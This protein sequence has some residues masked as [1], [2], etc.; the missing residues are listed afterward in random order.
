MR[1]SVVKYT[2]M[3]GILPRISDF[4]R[5]GFS[6]V[7]SFLAVIYG[8]VGLLPRNHPY[9]QPRNFG[10]F[11]IRHVFAEAGRNV[12]FSRDT[13][14]HVVIYFITLIAMVLI[15][16]QFVLL[17]FAFIYNPAFAGGPDY[18]FLLDAG[19]ASRIP[20][21]YNFFVLTPDGHSPSQDIA[22]VV[23]DKVFGIR[24]FSGTASTQSFF[25]SCVGDLIINTC[26]NIYGELSPLP[27][28]GGL[29]GGIPGFLPPINIFPKPIHFA[30]HNLLY[31]YTLGIAFL[32]GAVILYFIATIVGE[33]V[34]SGT[35]FG[36]RM[37][38]AWFIPRLIAFFA[39][40]APISGPS[41]SF[42]PLPGITNANNGINVAQL[43][44]FSAAKFG[45]NMAT[46][47]W[48]GF[49]DTAVANANSLGTAPPTA[50]LD[51][52][53]NNAVSTSFGVGQSM[54]ARPQVPEI[55]GLTHFTFLVRA[56]MYA[57][58]IMHG[59]PMRIYAVRPPSERTG[60]VRG[61]Q[62][63]PIPYTSLGNL[64]KLLDPAPAAVKEDSVDIT[65]FTD[66]IWFDML[67]S[68]ARFE[69]VVIRFGHRD[70]N[71]YPDEWGFVDP[72]CGEV[73]FQLTSLD[74]FVINNIAAPLPFGIQDAYFYLMMKMLTNEGV[75]ADELTYCMLQAT[76]PI[77]HRN[78]CVSETY[79][80]GGIAYPVPAP[81]AGPVDTHWLSTQAV[82]ADIEYFND[83]IR[84]LMIG[85]IS[86]W[87]LYTR[88]TNYLDATN[89]VGYITA[90]QNDE[91]VL[92]SVGPIELSVRSTLLM[93]VE[94]RQRGWAGA[95]LWYNRIAEINGM[96]SSAVNNK[97]VIYR[98]PRV[99]RQVEASHKS[100]TANLHEVE[101]FNP[102][103]PN[104]QLADLGRPGDQNI[105]ATLYSIHSFWGSNNIQETTYTRQSGNA[106]IDT[107][108]TL[109]GTSGIYDIANNSGTHPLAML[110]G[111]GKGMVDAALRNMFVGIVG[112]AGT[113]IGGDVVGPLAGLIGKFAFRFGMI[114][115]SIGFILYY[116]LPLMPFIYFFFA[117]SG[118][119]KSIFE[120]VVAMPLWAVAHIRIDGEGLPGPL[121]TN[122]YFLILEIFLRPSLII[123][124]FVLSVGIFTAL[125]NVLHS[126]FPLLVTVAGGSDVYMANDINQPL[127]TSI[128]P[129]V[130]PTGPAFEQKI[131]HIRK[132]VD[133]FF[134]T[135]I[136][137]IMVYMFALSSFKMVDAVPNN[138]MRWMGVTVSAFHEQAGDPAGE[139]SGKV[140]RGT[141]TTNAQIMQLMDRS[142]D[143][144]GGNSNAVTD[145]QLAG[146][147][148]SKS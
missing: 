39:L 61:L 11:G 59:T 118:W 94:V 128:I 74:P 9:L 76:L 145:A 148:G 113:L 56:C 17:L 70:Q 3:P 138:I 60:F 130:G 72:T 10:R 51:T 8:N 126:A 141:Q 43:I 136:Y 103:L 36:R 88:Q 52:D 110:S 119:I 111:L 29:F 106:V 2:L 82:R 48:L 144:L 33:T 44:V 12:V 135:I 90:N 142:G 63:I 84:E 132:P 23:L 116:V 79:S 54:I 91:S 46:N 117:F 37:N 67:V 83:F 115:L 75:A 86:D 147:I 146:A 112:T 89:V 101:R 28:P 35:P 20:T 99:M 1:S 123:A 87:D 42:L 137:V 34:T 129:S 109:L 97:P 127:N 104:G 16:I 57:E 41:N 19:G 96:I 107:V 140:Y 120:A 134:Y 4:F 62:G 81:A 30:L 24:Q 68:F 50:A 7:A 85:D 53:G 18:R 100:S 108:N 15:I 14:D 66:F 102:R 105:A 69:T 26:T 55:G 58:E 78:R 124:G 125:V 13:L 93:P 139:L 5:S 65:L 131:E 27:I 77:H 122:G 133:E 73:H 22:F 40:I 92:L 98:Y 64:L 32:A 143:A 114:A 80:V 21:L 49:V 45:S 38:R 71:L 25:D 121:A 47:L 31:F 95:S 6:F